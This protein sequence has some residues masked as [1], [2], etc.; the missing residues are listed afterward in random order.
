M[1][2]IFC[3]GPRFGEIFWRRCVRFGVINFEVGK[4]GTV[5]VRNE[6]I[7]GGESVRCEIIN[8]GGVK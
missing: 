5:G 7:E 8:K 2:N 4:M 1:R 6:L 3:V